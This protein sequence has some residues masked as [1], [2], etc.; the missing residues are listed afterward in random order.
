[1]I[2]ATDATRKQFLLGQLGKTEEV[3]VETTKSPLGYEGF[4]KNYTPVYV[5]CD[6]ALCGNVVKM[7]L[8]AVLE[9][10]CVGTLL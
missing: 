1:M 3:L 5:S 4:A 9:G 7:R 8:E 2:E 10:H 6:P